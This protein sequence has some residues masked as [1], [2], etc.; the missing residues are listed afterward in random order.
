MIE[1]VVSSSVLIVVVILLRTLL[2]GKIKSRLQY[3][4][5]ALVLVRLLVPVSFGSTA[6]SV[7]NTARQVPVVQDAAELRG[8]DS[9]EHMQGGSVEGYAQAGRITDRPTTIAENKSDAEFARM[10]TVLTVRE[11]LLPPWKVGVLVMLAAFALSNLRF[12]R[13]LRRRRTRLERADYPLPVYVTD[14]VETPCLFGLVRPAVY[15]TPEVQENPTVLRHALA[16]ELT[17]FRHGDHIWAILRCACLALH[18]YNP[19]VWAAAILSRRDAELACDEGTIRRIGESERMEY[20]RT[21]IDLTCTKREPSALFCTATTMTGSKKSIYERVTRIAKAPKMLGVTV[22]AV[23]LAAALAV[24]CTFTGAQ[25][26]KSLQ[27]ALNTL[28]ADY[29]DSVMLK[30]QADLSEGLFLSAYYAADYDAKTDFGWLLNVEQWDQAALEK[31]LCADDTSGTV[32]FA[33]DDAHYYAVSSPTDVRCSPENGDDYHTIQENLMEWAKNTVLSFAGVEAMDEQALRNQPFTYEGNHRDVVYYP[34]YAVNG[35]RT[36]EWTLLLSQPVTQGGGGIWCVERWQGVGEFLDTHLVRPDTELTNAAYYADLQKQADSGEAA[37]ACSPTEVCLR[38]V[39]TLGGE[40]RN[41]TAD[42]FSMGEVY[43]SVPG[44]G[45]EQAAEKLAKLRSNGALT[46]ELTLLDNG[47]YEPR[48]LTFSSGDSNVAALFSDLTS[49]YDWVNTHR[50]GPL[51]TD[52]WGDPDLPYFF[53]VHGSDIHYAMNLYAGGT[54]LELFDRRDN[55]IFQAVPKSGDTDIAAFVRTWFDAAYAANPGQTADQ[56]AQLTLDTIISGSTVAMELTTA[57][58]AGGGRYGISPD[59]GNGRNR[60]FS[61]TEPSCFRW[62]FLQN[63]AVPSPEPDTLTVETPDRAYALQFWKGSETVRCITTDG[64]RWLRAESMNQEDAFD[65][66]I[67]SYMRFWYDEAEF[68]ALAGNIV[69]PDRGQSHQEILQTWVDAVTQTFLRVTPGS[70]YA[71]T[72]ARS[73]GKLW[74]DYENDGWY[75]PHMLETEHFYFSYIRIFVPE[76]EI[77]RNWQMA[78]NTGDYDGSYGEAPAGA[79]SCYQMGPMYLSADGWRCG[80]TGT[81]P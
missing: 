18:W 80:G 13:V 16:H 3:A 60:Q 28:P 65:E 38:F 15:L 47:G 24:G 32:C 48:Q 57:D 33:R 51:S 5:W 72:Y 42:S 37:W 75:Q 40:H 35:D 17:H 39:S 43:S 73:V 56:L 36:G 6:V 25:A 78:G 59:D 55:L 81:G 45:N 44:S 70:K 54:Q 61:F 27:D 52:P 22:A 29:T 66:D 4:L 63:G 21:L 71:C 2:R 20:G 46:F 14:A 31:H 50:Q 30:P 62:S 34:Y 9:I 26:P 11:L 8:F 7:M 1:W 76:N 68:A 12:R 77:S 41:A 67:F 79:Q 23:I 58:G 69:I 53:Y 19:L 74:D 49:Q 10:K 64:E